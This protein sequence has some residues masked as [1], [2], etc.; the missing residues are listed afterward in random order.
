MSLIFCVCARARV[1]VYACVRVCVCVCVRVCV[2]V[3]VKAFAA[4]LVC[5]DQFVREF[6]KLIIPIAD[7]V[8]T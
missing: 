4:A 6:H 1:C 5:S 2:S 3:R 8:T 7:V